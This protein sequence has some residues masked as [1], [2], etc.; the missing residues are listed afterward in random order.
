MTSGLFHGLVAPPH[1]AEEIAE[2]ADRVVASLRDLSR[3]E[4]VLVL[5]VALELVTRDTSEPSAP[6]SSSSIPSSG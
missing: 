5:R 2:R 1:A 3:A 6:T 4:A